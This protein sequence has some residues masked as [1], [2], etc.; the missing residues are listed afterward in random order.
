LSL[1]VDL[2]QSIPVELLL[3]VKSWLKQ[4]DFQI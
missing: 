4:L 3:W 1:E 2:Q